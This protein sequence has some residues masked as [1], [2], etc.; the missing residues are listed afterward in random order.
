M[1]IPRKIAYNVVISSISKVAST[2]L[3]LVGIGMIA[4]YLG[5]DGFGMYAT[6]LAFFSFFGALGD[7]GIY[8][9]FTRD[10][11]RPGADEASIV[12][13]VAG[14]RIVVSSAILAIAPLIAYFSPYDKELKYAIFITALAFFFSS[15]YQFIIGFFQK[16]LIMDKVALAEFLGKIVQ[17]GTVYLGVKFQFGLAFIT[18][19]ILFNMI[20]VLMFLIIITQKY[21]HFKIIFD[22]TFMKTF[23]ISTAPIGLATLVAFIY[24]KADTIILSLLKSS[25]EVGIYGAAF[26]IIEN[27][28]FFPAMIVGLTMPLFSH[29]I[30]ADRLKFQ[31]MV[32]KNFKVFLVLVMPLIV[33]TL[34]LA[35]GIIRIVTG[36]GFEQ[37]ATVLRIV[38]FSLGLIFFGHLSNSVLI[39]AGLQKYMLR[40][41]IF[42]ALFSIVGNFL[43]VPRFSFLATAWINVITELLVV[44]LTGYF[45]I[46][47]LGLKIDLKK[48]PRILLAS[49]LMAGFLK[50]FSNWNF[51]LLLLA[52]PIVY[53]VV[54]TILKVFSKDEIF[55]LIKKEPIAESIEI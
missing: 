3:A 24:G 32:N 16:K 6:A 18:S 53:F 5:Q 29:S 43:F 33:G 22:R 23:L 47:K 26:K 4:R 42:C 12:S 51:F 25:Q 10:I 27:V 13:R 7:W 9:S 46:K 36:P 2:A 50:L 28:T 35:D 31:R 55:S 45:A 17:V 54:L 21:V 39:S 15:F 14:L 34:F 44:I 40:V 19:S 11:S 30:I 1:S 41:F 20:F 49:I 52:S 8:Q 38:I 37:S 48:V